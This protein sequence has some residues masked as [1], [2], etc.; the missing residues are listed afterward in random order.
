M[1]RESSS[2][3][4]SAGSRRERS[5]GP[6]AHREA[7]APVVVRR[8]P[9]Q[10]RGVFATRAIAKGDRIIEYTGERIT[11]EEAAERYDDE[12]MRRHHT[13]VFTIDDE[14]CID[15]VKQGSD[16]R[17]I[18]HS[19]AP[20]AKSVIDRRRI[21]II[22]TRDIRAGEEVLYDYWYSTDESYTLDDLMRLYPCRCGASSCRGTLAAVPPRHLATK[23]RAA[24]AT[25]A[26]RKRGKRGK[27]DQRNGSR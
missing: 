18:N 20:N 16:A 22:A 23:R 27:R 15:A 3:G 8:S 19:C 25:D 12:R 21:Y 24:G 17:Y 1:R 2:T 14:L 6:G 5:K 9:I 4:A 7:E 10:G 13:F 26:A 11:H